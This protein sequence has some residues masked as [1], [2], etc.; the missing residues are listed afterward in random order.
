MPRGSVVV[1]TEGNPVAIKHRADL[2][3]PW[4]WIVDNAGL[5][6]V[7]L[8][9]LRRTTASFMISGGASLATVGK[10]LGHTQ[11]ST[12][13]RYA[14]LSQSVQREELRKAGE[15]MVGLWRAGGAANVAQMNSRG[16]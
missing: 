14:Q 13:Q 7:R 12:T 1:D 6:D 10:A 9:D 15:R 2:K 16:N 3:K 4:Q 11:A 8:H 5:V